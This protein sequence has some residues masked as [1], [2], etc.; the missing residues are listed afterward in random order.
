[1]YMQPDLHCKW[2]C[3]S[4]QECD[5]LFSSTMMRFVITCVVKP[6]YLIWRMDGIASSIVGIFMHEHVDFAMVGLYESNTGD[7]VKTR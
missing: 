3:I 6:F 7:Y 1:M 2:S 4:T 5:D